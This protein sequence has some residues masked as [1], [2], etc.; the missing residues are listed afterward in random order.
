[1]NNLNLPIPDPGIADTIAAIKRDIFYSLNV[2]VIGKI[3][4]FNLEKK[5]A[6]IEILFKAIVPD[7][8]NTSGQKIV[9]Y[10]ILVDCPIFTLQG[11]GGSVQMPIAAG[12]QCVVLFA[13]RNI[14]LWFQNGASALPPDNRTHDLSDGI[15]FVGIN[16]L[17][18]S[19]ANYSASELRISMG[20]A[21]VGITGNKVTLT[22]GTD[23][24]LT[25]I[26]GLI[27]I[28]AAITDANSIPLSPASIAALGGYKTTVAGL[29]Y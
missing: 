23:T 18:S 27:D 19:L 14:D 6:Q 16:A 10:P 2:C 21:K 29:L 7:S 25:V 12:D 28:I 3:L 20:T 26:D 5:T 11:G 17:T 4:S 8:L 13:D 22:N 9:S 1:M 15:A 24:L